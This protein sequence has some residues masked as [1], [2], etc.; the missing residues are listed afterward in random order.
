MMG[1][2]IVV[3]NNDDDERGLFA[4]ILNRERWE[5]F[6]YD[7]AH[8]GLSFLQQLHPDLIILDFN[9]Q[10]GGTSWE[11]LQLLKMEDATAHVPILITTKSDQLS[12]EIQGYLLTRYIHVVYKPFDADSFLS[13]VR[14]TLTLASQA[15]IVLSRDRSF[16][17]LVVEDT[18]VLREGLATILRLE[19]YRAVTADNGLRALG[20]V[21]D[22]ELCLILLDMAM[23]TMDGLEF[24]RIYHRQPR[25]HTP[26]II[27]SGQ[28]VPPTSALPPFVLDM[29]SKPFEVSHLLRVVQKY[30]SPLEGSPAS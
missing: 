17:I 4:I 27:L 7:Y 23:P 20:A 26:V 12:V 25:P 8:I 5:V 18:E 9:E 11:F 1:A 30:A 21:Y 3:I 29:V 28:K 14:Q 6:S 13:L 24:L 19:G 15:G 10:D 22:A 16:P 2:R